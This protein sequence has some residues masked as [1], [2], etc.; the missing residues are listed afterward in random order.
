MA[1][2]AT[3]VDEPSSLRLLVATWNVGCTAPPDSLSD[4]LH[5][6]RG[7]HLV[8]VC[9]QEVQSLEAPL[10]YLSCSRLSPLAQRWDESVGAALEGMERVAVRQLVGM[11]LLVYA[12]SPL[13]PLLQVRTRAAGTGPLGAGNKGAVAATLLLRGSSLT[14]L[15]CHLAAGK[16]GPQRRNAEHHELIERM[17]LGVQGT[18]DSM[19]VVPAGASGRQL[20][21]WCGDLNYRL[22][23]ANEEARKLAAT[24]DV[25]G[26][27][28]ADE[29]R[30]CR[31][32]GEAFQGF[33][34]AAIGFAPT[35]KYDLDSDSFDS[36]KKRRAPAYCDRI[37]WRAEP[38]IVCES[39]VMETGMR[40]SDHR[41]VSAVLNV[42]LLPFEPALQ[43]SFRDDSEGGLL[44][45]LLSVCARCDHSVPH[46][47]RL[48]AIF[49]LLT[50][51]YRRDAN[52]RVSRTHSYVVA[53][54][55][56]RCLP[57]IRPSSASYTLLGT[58]PPSL[59]N[60]FTS[61]YGDPSIVR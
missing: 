46:S 53:S 37:L 21:F 27:L 28:A 44:S 32:R 36:S 59:R 8:A 17:R 56:C 55:P 19:G 39:Y 58:A 61:K 24:G 34:E 49:Y 2:V 10:S 26:L 47:T 29:L 43:P 18:D 5:A 60:S 57:C 4:W 9:L 42:E 11:L 41:A 54:P 40:S 6:G 23:L 45:S 3:A 25:R 22:T 51:T 15:C 1:A 30:L 38:N 33:E 14:F 13:A 50:S 12:A 31:E 7:S 52:P 48:H 35:Y 20:L 16:K